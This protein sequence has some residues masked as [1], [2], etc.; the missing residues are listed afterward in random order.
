MRH[1]IFKEADTYETA[2]LIKASSFN[3]KSLLEHYVDPL[4]QQGVSKDSLICFTLEYGQ[5]GKCPKGT[6]EPYLNNLLPALKNLGVKNILCAD[7]QYFKS[8]TKVGKVDPHY[9]YVLPC[10]YENSTTKDKYEDMTVT[11][12]P[13][14]GA[15][16]YK[17]EIQDKL[18]MAIS[19]L[20]DLLKGQYKEL[21]GDIIHSA[22]YPT[23]Y[24]SIRQALEDLHQ[25]PMLSCDVE[26]F[27]LKFWE[28]GIGTIGFAW[29]EHN[30]L[31][32]P[33]D[34]EEHP[35]QVSF[36]RRQ[37]IRDLLKNFFETYQGK[38]IWHNANFDLKIVVNTL[39]MATLLDEKGK[40]KGIE[41]MTRG[42]HDTKIVTYLATNSTSGNDLSLK[43]QAHE[44][45]G[46]WAQSDIEDITNIP[47]PDLLRYNLVDCLSTWYV[48]KK[49]APT[50][51]ADK[52][53]PIYNNIM[54]PSVKV[55]L[56]MELTG[57]PIDMKKV[58]E[59]RVILE[60]EIDKHEK[61]LQGL[62]FIQVLEEDLTRKAWE[63]DY[64]DRVKKAKHPENIK[65]KDWDTFKTSNKAIVF[66]PGSNNQ[67]QYLL[68]EMLNLPVLDLTDSKQP[69]VGGDTLKK[70]KNHTT[71]ITV[72]ELIDSLME[73]ADA[74]K[75]LGT[76]IKAFE[77]AVLKEDGWHYLHG[78][79]NLGGTVSG[80]LS[81]SGPN[82]QNIP[83]T[84][85]KWA[86]IVKMCFVAPPGW[87][88]A[89][90]DFASLEDRISALTTRDPEKLKVYTDGY[91]G[92]CLRAYAYFGDQMPDIK[93]TV[94][95]INSIA[96]KYKPLRQASKVPTFALTYGGTYHAIMDQTGLP[97]HEAKAIEDNYHKL[98]HVSDKWVEDKVK[99][100]TK[101]GY[102]TVA[103]GLRVRTPLLKQVLWGS[104][105]TPYE[106][107]KEGRTAGNA[108]GQSYGLLNNRAAIEFQEKTLNSH[109]AE[110]ILP[111]AHIH[112]AQYFL[113]RNDS[114][115][116]K[117]ANDGISEAMAWQGLPEIYHPEVPLGGELDIFYPSWADDITLPNNASEDEII[118]L[119]TEKAAA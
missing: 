88:F 66:N 15:I 43:A 96:K 83:S 41:V 25:Y 59:A 61:I 2:I 107:R 73:V 58:K 106:A 27:S 3:K 12:A 54:I 101:D 93:Q 51:T 112:D 77:G 50:M 60:A 34:L 63:K 37:A 70:L 19:T 13:N 35:N 42:F 118:N 38:L 26:T 68:Y 97:E 95:S 74:S 76:F 28:T 53:L 17:P 36:L 84:G 64:Q 16:F 81:S 57:M 75:I 72:H 18:N 8:L 79:F 100:A 39:W 55:I 91:D 9:G 114:A 94:E 14:Y 113:I 30:G 52:Q 78:N 1:L 92:H 44:F 102:V 103:F 32:F 99:Q 108:L 80:R 5:N 22:S 24:L 104:K 71:N 86:K 7:S 62:P 33:V 21:G 105:K 40:Q 119:C 23:D 116:M 45:A 87:I 46:N 109:F 47:K 49:H 11:L 69:A 31:A 82:M 98:Y 85:N 6:W 90:A 117:F 56:Q 29:D 10:K 115:A 4:V 20:S 65:R 110:D 111:S 48:Y 67:I 89:G